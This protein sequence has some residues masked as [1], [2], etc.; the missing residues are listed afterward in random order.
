M[1]YKWKP[2]EAKKNYIFF[3]WEKKDLLYEIVIKLSILCVINIIVSAIYFQRKMRMK[4]N[5]K[6]KNR[7]EKKIHDRT[8][9]KKIFQQTRQRGNDIQLIVD[10]F[11][12]AL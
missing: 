8:K 1:S 10:T 7:N 2:V 9:L 6:M 3:E 11:T 12:F 5:D 4:L